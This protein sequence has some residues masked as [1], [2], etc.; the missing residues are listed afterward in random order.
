MALE[1]ATF[2]SQLVATN[3]VGATDPKAQGDDHLRLIKG[4]LQSQFPNLGAAAITATAAEINRLVG[5]T[6]PVEDLRG[7]PY[8]NQAGSYTL[9]ASD[10]GQA[11]RLTAGTNVNIPTLAAKFCCVIMNETGAAITL[12]KTV[13]GNNRWFNGGNVAPPTG[14]RTL[15][16]AGVAFISH[17]GTDARMWGVGLA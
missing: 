13:A 8:N 10:A 11:V 9:A 15:N 16:A 2:I 17:D 4:V 14:T 1:A 5:I 12:T 7:L 6:G 3:P